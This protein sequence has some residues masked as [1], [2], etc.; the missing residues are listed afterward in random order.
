MRWVWLWF[1]K[2]NSQL[3]CKCRWGR[4]VA[5]TMG[6]VSAVWWMKRSKKWKRNGEERSLE[7][8]TITRPNAYLFTQSSCSNLDPTRLVN[9]KL[10]FLLVYIYN[11]LSISALS[12]RLTMEI[13]D[14]VT[15]P[16]SHSQFEFKRHS[17][18]CILCFCHQ[19][20][21]ML[22]CGIQPWYLRHN[23]EMFTQNST[24]LSRSLATRQPVYDTFAYQ[25]AKKTGTTCE[26]ICA[27]RKA[28]L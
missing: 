10:V 6:K 4:S 7:R 14:S 1:G 13:S 15:S 28:I 26:C 17:A 24:F 9:L 18:N 27:I 2:W 3:K 5:F 12:S 22:F 11:L 20:L 19:N 16:D 8:K 21:C 23:R 25:T